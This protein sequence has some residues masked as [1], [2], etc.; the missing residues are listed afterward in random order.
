MKQKVR[1]LIRVF[2]RIDMS[3]LPDKHN[4][5]SFLLDTDRSKQTRRQMLKVGYQNLAYV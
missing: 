1:W 3:S 2:L 4:G 5:R